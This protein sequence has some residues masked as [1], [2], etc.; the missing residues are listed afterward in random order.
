[1]L[2]KFASSATAAANSFKVSSKFGAPSI[3]LLIAFVTKVSVAYPARL[4]CG[5]HPN[6]PAPFVA[7]TLPLLPSPV[8]HFTAPILI[9]PVPLVR[10]SKS[11]L[12]V[13]ELNLSNFTRPS[14]LI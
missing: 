4:G 12:F 9:L 11:A 8:G 13:T 5:I 3:R 10:I 7:N 14:Y 1:M 6:S 2:A